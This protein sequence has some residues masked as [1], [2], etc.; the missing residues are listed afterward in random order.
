M[1]DEAERWKKLIEEANDFWFQTGRGSL[2]HGNV[3]VHLETGA[4][5]DVVELLA[6][7]AFRLPYQREAAMLPK[8]DLMHLQEIA[9][10]LMSHD[11]YRKALEDHMATCP[12]PPLLM[13]RSCPHCGKKLVED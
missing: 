4:H 13:F 3:T 11:P 12:G 10:H 8:Q 6:E 9:R 2:N 1:I 7:F 5:F